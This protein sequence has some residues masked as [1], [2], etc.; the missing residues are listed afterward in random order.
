LPASFEN[1]MGVSSYSEYDINK[2]EDLGSF[3]TE[4]THFV[5]TLNKTMESENSPHSTKK[6]S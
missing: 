5:S 2:K 4:Q 6:L 1:K 3:K